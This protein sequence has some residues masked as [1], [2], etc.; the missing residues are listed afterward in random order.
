MH[1]DSEQ[2]VRNDTERLWAEDAVE[3]PRPV[4][5]TRPAPPD[6]ADPPVLVVA[7]VVGAFLLIL[8]GAL[9]AGLSV[10]VATAL[11]WALWRYVPRRGRAHTTP[12][13][14][15]LAEI[16]R[17]LQAARRPASGSRPRQRRRGSADR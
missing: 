7:G 17:G 10:G 3:S 4:P 9:V 15:V 2:R 11:G 13:W 1:S 12:A 6:P 14:A 5:V 16:N 8:L